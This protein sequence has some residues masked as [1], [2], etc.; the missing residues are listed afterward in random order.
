MA[1]LQEQQKKE[2]L[3]REN[4]TTILNHIREFNKDIDVVNTNE[5]EELQKLERDATKDREKLQQE[6]TDLQDKLTKIQNLAQQNQDALLSN[7]DKIQREYT[8]K[9]DSSASKI[10][11]R[12]QN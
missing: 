2:Q 3:Y 12:N 11:E 8:R 5:R 1:D 7:S 9:R 10:K 4:E 6:Q